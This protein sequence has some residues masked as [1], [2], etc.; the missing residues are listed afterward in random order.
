MKW[1]LL[2]AGLP[3]AFFDL[4]AS[5][6]GSDAPIDITTVYGETYHRCHLYKIT[7][8]G[9]TVLHDEGVANIGFD[10]LD[11]S[12]KEQYHYDPAK[13]RAY[14]KRLEAERKV[15][16]AR[17]KDIQ[18]RREREDDKMMKNLVALEKKNLEA[19][20]SREKA[21]AE[22]AQA[23]NPPPLA[24]LPGEDPQQML[25]TV[26]TAGS[27]LGNA[28]SGVPDSPALGVP[29]TPGFGGTPVQGTADDSGYYP[30]GGANIFILNTR[31]GHYGRHP[32]MP[33]APNPAPA[34]TPP[35]NVSSAP[36]YRVG[37]GTVRSVH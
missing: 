13:A 19:E 21:L 37:G 15:T 20:S 18:K 30:P 9:I 12:W 22:A 23:Q 27:G 36:S 7:P 25:D 14:L 1:L 16:E 24:P 6:A 32:S 8:A 31:R 10:L 34:P 28:G 3:F 17:R 29:Y 11:S 26:S 35:S 4:K 2:L 5:D 33:P